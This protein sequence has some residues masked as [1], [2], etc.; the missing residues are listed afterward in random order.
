MSE[1]SDGRAFQNRK[2][3]IANIGLGGVAMDEDLDL[4]FETVQIR[5]VFLVNV[6]LN[7]GKTWTSAHLE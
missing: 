4:E 3:T 7:P 1:E 5:D 6:S 2:R